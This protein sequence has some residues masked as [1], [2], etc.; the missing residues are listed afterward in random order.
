M[1]KVN[2]LVE[3]KISK[4][5]RHYQILRKSNVYDGEWELLDL[6]P[7][8]TIKSWWQ[9]LMDHLFAADPQY[10]VKSIH[11]ARRIKKMLDDKEV[12]WLRNVTW[13]DIEHE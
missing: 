12:S 7:Y 6:S 5:G 8:L 13:D 11:E 4:K 2:K 1:T 9:N 10:T 3:Y